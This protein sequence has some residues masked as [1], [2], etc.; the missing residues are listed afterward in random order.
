MGRGWESRDFR[1]KILSNQLT[2]FILLSSYSIILLFRLEQK[3]VDGT[4]DME[5]ALKAFQRLKDEFQKEF[6]EFELQVPCYSMH[7]TSL[8]QPTIVKFITPSAYVLCFWRI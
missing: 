4:L 7:T 5:L 1:P 3:F 8:I 2:M 6:R